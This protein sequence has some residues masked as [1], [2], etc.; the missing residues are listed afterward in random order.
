MFLSIKLTCLP[1]IFAKKGKT[2]QIQIGIM[3]H[4]KQ[5]PIIQLILIHYIM[6]KSVEY[7]AGFMFIGKAK[8][9]EL[10]ENST[11]ITWFQSKTTQK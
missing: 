6:K 9:S 11:M 1:F 10:N 3:G 8:S 7:D 4:F 5:R 2:G